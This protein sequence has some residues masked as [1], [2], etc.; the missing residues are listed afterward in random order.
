M[1]KTITA[2]TTL[3]LFFLAILVKLTAICFF[4]LL[5]FLGVLIILV[6]H[7]LQKET[8]SFSILLP[9]LPPPK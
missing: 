1:I 5:I 4:G 7:F 8:F 2:K 9:Q 6:P 3:V